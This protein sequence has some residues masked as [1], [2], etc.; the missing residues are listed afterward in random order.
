MKSFICCENVEFSFTIYRNDASEIV[1]KGE[2]VKYSKARANMPSRKAKINRDWGRGMATAGKTKSNTS[3]PKHHF[4][5]IPG[6]DVGMSWEYRMQCSEVG[7][8]GPHMA[9]IAAQAK[10]GCQSLVLAGGYED[11]EDFGNEFTYTGEIFFQ[12]ILLYLN[13]THICIF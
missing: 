10:I 11:D 8:H 12:I 4:G 13:I 7:V 1:N 2:A 9:G 5:P 3:I 6:V